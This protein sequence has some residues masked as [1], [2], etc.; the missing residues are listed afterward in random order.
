MP[1]SECGKNSCIFTSSILM[2]G[3]LG[4]L[5]GYFVKAFGCISQGVTDD[6][7]NPL[8]SMGVGSATGVAVSL[9]VLAGYYC[10]NKS[11]QTKRNKS[12]IFP[13]SP[14]PTAPP[15]PAITFVSSPNCKLAAAIYFARM[16]D[17]HPKMP[18]PLAVDSTP[19]A[20]SPT[21]TSG[22]DCPSAFK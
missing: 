16:S 3:N 13:L 6:E 15:R 12:Q 20:S 22:F 9:L 21:L 5:A 11:T 4:L 18:S 14:S 7:C 2:G 8:L 17:H 1:N 19:Q 10:Y